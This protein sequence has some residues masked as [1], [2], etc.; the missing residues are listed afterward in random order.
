[1]S[2]SA[3]ATIVRIPS[4][5]VPAYAS[6]NPEGLAVA[7]ID[8]TGDASAGTISGGMVSSGQ[9]LYRLE[10]FNINRF[11]TVAQGGAELFTLA[12]WATVGAGFGPNSFDLLWDLAFEDNG[13]SQRLTLRDRYFD[14]IHRIPLGS[15]RNVDV[16]N[17]LFYQGL[18]NTNTVVHD[19]SAM[20]TYWRKEALALPGFLQSFYEAPFVPG[21]L[22]LGPIRGRGA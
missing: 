3:S 12:D 10:A 20:F 14:Q 8:V 16:T 2:I 21:G 6:P 18:A 4:A 22:A 1:M 11:D 19:I 15:L 9:F 17:V 5:G 13:T 7:H